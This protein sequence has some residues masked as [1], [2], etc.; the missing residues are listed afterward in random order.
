MHEAVNVI[1]FCCKF[2]IRS[3]RHFIFITQRCSDTLPKISILGT[4]VG[5]FYSHPDYWHLHLV[6]RKPH[7][8]KWNNK[9]ANTSVHCAVCASEQSDLHMCC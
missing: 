2:Q 9:D 5:N 1:S 7:F 6:L 3:F 8:L 4:Q